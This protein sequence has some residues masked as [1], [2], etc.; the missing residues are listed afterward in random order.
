MS[1]NVLKSI[2]LNSK[3]KAMR[4][5]VTISVVSSQFTVLMLRERRIYFHLSFV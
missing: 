1:K 2:L 4:S 5:S 3:S